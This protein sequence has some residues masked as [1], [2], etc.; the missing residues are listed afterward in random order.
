[1]A[2]L[3]FVAGSLLLAALLPHIARFPFLNERSR[4]LFGIFSSQ[5]RAGTFTLDLKPFFEGDAE[6]AQDRL[7]D[8]A[9][10][11]WA[12]VGDLMR[13]LLCLG[14][15]LVCRHHG[16]DEADAI[17]FLEMT[18]GLMALRTSGRLKVRYAMPSRFSYRN[19]GVVIEGSFLSH[20]LRHDL[21]TD[22]PWA[23]P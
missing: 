7:F 18:S 17:R 12:V 5:D 13:T 10:G 4:S 11:D 1:M 6:A 19:A 3:W 14:H 23:R 8:L 20:K 21:G 2:N 9:H 22:P 16:V 15:E